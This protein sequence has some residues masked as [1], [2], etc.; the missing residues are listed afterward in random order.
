[1]VN[2][3]ND[4]IKSWTEENKYGEKDIF[5]ALHIRQPQKIIVVQK[6]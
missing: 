3:R 1:M 4:V 6:T 2:K 5:N